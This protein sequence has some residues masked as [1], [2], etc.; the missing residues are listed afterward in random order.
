MLVAPCGYGLDGAAAQAEVVAR[1]LPDAEV[2]AIDGN[3]V[4]VRPGP[5]LVEGVEAIASV[6]HPDA[7]P[8]SHHVRRLA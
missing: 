8:A 5:R 1:E 4:V 6:L 3:A 2:W 7:V